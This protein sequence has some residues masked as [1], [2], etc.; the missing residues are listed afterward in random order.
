MEP[1]EALSWVSR[2]YEQLAWDQ[3]YLQAGS[4]ATGASIIALSCMLSTYYLASIIFA[5][6]ADA[7]VT[8]HRRFLYAKCFT[9]LTSSRRSR[10]ANL[11]HFRLKNVINIKAWISLRGGRTWLKRQGRQRAADEIVSTSFLVIL[12]LLVVMGMQ[13]VSDGSGTLQPEGIVH[14]EVAIWCM[15]SRYASDLLCFMSYSSVELTCL[16]VVLCSIFMLRFMMLGSNINKKYQNTSLLLTEQLNS[17]NKVSGLTMN[18][19]LYNLT[20]VVVLSAF[21][22]TASEFFGFKLKLWKLKA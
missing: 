21:S 10:L 8:Y 6:L 14:V 4:L 5:A 17:P 16:A 19:L 7:E 3:L 15:L 11:P 13:A 22:S 18:P 2:V 12:V 1:L 20:R 9:A